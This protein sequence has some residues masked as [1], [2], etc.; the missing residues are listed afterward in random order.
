MRVG[1]TGLVVALSL[2]LAVPA[3]GSEPPAQPGKQTYEDHCALC[4]GPAGKGDGPVGLPVA[5]MPRDFSVGRFKF[6]ADSDG[7]T[8]T[9][10]DLFL[11]IRD[12]AAEFGGSPLMAPWA[13]LGDERIRELIPYVRSFEKSAAR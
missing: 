9:D 5:P 12:G 4:H 10:H 8:G 3:A 1:S 7:R 11:V 6:D 13:A 2:A